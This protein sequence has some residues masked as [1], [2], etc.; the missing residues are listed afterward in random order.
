MNPPNLPPPF[1]QSPPPMVPLPPVPPRK[2]MGAGWI[3]LIIVGAV[4]AVCAVLAALALP[5]Y[6][7]IQRMAEEM[8]QKESQAVQAP[9][10]LTEAQKTALVQFGNDLADALSEKNGARVLA[11][12]DAEGFCARVFEKI[13][14]GIPNRA[15]MRRGFMN[16]I[17]K[18]DGGWLWS[19]MSGD[20]HFL[21]T[22]ER[23][24]F[25]AVLLRIKTPE[26]AVSYVDIL[27][28]PEGGGFRI[29]DMFNYIFATTA[30]EE[31]RNV[32]AAM[33]SKSGGSGLSALL[34]TPHLD[35]KTAGFFVRINDAT[36]T[37]N[38]AEV[39]RICDSL[40]PELKTQRI[41]F[42]VRLQALMALSS[43]AKLDQ[44]YKEALRAAPDILGK[45]STTDLLMVDL[46]FMENDFKGAEE[47]LKRLD[48]I[49][50]GDPYVKFLRAA[51]RLQA[52]DYA[53]ALE[54]ANE[55]GKEDPEMADVVDLRLA[56]YLAQK[57]FKAVVN[58][59]RE[60]KRNFGQVLDRK[61]LTGEPQ[62]AE[63]LTSPEFAAWEKEA[64]QP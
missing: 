59:L 41:F 38:M 31:S 20:V 29:V 30:S 33:L 57:D 2:G 35:E 55:A 3:V 15:D 23:L 44:Q 56:V 63:F 46:L 25:P 21:R 48:K 6:Q 36:R 61:A 8:K 42:I 10:P 27:V 5:A 14:S 4:V 64:A 34:G 9:V 26:G 22:R 7:R 24:G 53:G 1:P 19:A 32:L 54:M 37:G 62:Y 16:G 50:G 18:R 43:T 52:K 12:Q 47:C 28:R 13:P 11:M 58:E 45:D 39:L 49:I 17:Q 60:F 40:P 51:A